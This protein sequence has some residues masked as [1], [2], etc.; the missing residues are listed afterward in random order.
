MSLSLNHLPTPL[1]E[2]VEYLTVLTKNHKIEKLR[3]LRAC[4]EDI[5]IDIY[6]HSSGTDS[7]YSDGEKRYFTW[8]EVLKKSKDFIETGA[9]L[10]TGVIEYKKG[11]HFIS[12]ATA[13]DPNL[14]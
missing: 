11:I 12:S 7:Y 5:T 2:K 1:R 13:P 9:N 6:H 4:S 8:L 3:E 14:N 10:F